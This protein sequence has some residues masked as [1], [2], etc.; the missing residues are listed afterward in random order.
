[1]PKKSDNPQGEEKKVL[2][3]IDDTKKPVS[4]AGASPGADARCSMLRR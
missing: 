1:M 2:D 3:L 4:V